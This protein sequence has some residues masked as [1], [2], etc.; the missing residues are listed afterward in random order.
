MRAWMACCLISV[1]FIARKAYSEARSW[2]PFLDKE[3]LSAAVAIATI[4][5]VPLGKV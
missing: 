4:K 2:K 3:K 5:S 1:S